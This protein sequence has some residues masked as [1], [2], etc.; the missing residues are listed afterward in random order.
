L[1]AAF[2]YS[3]GYGATVHG[4]RQPTLDDNGQVPT[5]FVDDDPTNVFS[6]RLNNGVAGHSFTVPP[7]QIYLRV[8][9][10]DELTDGADDLDLYLFF[11]VNNQCSQLA[12]SDGVTSD[13]EINIFQ[14][15]PGEYVVLV[16]GYET[17][18]IAGGPGANYSLFTWSFG[19]NDIVGNLS[20][21][22]PATVGNGDRFDFPLQWSTLEPASRYLGAISHTTPAGLYGLTIVNVTTP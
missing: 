9:L 13:E 12:E 20:I 22:A 21:T 3:G 8:A 7:N 16:H 17:D 18:Q 14:P 19:N 6:F 15:V 1:P 2:G 5:G 10:F 4:L 11:C